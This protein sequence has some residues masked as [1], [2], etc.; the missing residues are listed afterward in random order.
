MADHPLVTT[1]LI[2]P[3]D[4]ATAPY[5]AV[6]SRVGSLID[7]QPLAWPLYAGAWNAVSYRF[8]ACADHDEAFTASVERAGGS[9]P[10]SERYV[11][12]RE[13]FNFFVNGLATMESLCFG[14]FA[15]GSMLAL[16]DFPIATPKDLRRITPEWTAKAYAS[17]FPGEQITNALGQLIG[18]QCFI[19]WNEVRNVLA[20][21][22]APG[23]AHF[24][25]SAVSIPSGDASAAVNTP[26]DPPST[27]LNGI[28]IDANTTSVRRAWL[29][30]TARELLE[31]TATFTATHL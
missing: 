3:K 26:S 20:H 6:H 27:W 25:A 21:R 22:S 16:P 19:K 30:D 13:L 4:F 18:E 17:A 9:P 14:L 23:R 31:A 24:R 10:S 1:G 12:E 2:M 29:A 11:Q 5:T 8:Q 15:I 7:A 28:P